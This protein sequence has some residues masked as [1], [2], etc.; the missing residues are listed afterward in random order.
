MLITYKKP[1]AFCELVLAFE[2]HDGAR[3]IITEV[4]VGPEEHSSRGPFFGWSY[5]A[6]LYNDHGT[7]T[8][9]LRTWKTLSGE[10]NED[11]YRDY[12]RL[13]VHFSGNN[14]ASWALRCEAPLGRLKPTS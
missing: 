1:D 7:W 5:D 6:Q 13:Q 12:D 3:S 4:Y 10:P 2:R 9:L 8:L 14:G 11:P